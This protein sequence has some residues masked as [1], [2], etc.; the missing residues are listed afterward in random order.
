MYIYKNGFSKNVFLE[1]LKTNPL[2]KQIMDA[3]DTT[4]KELA[5]TPIPELEYSKFKLF[6]SIGDRI[7]YE[8]PYFD[9][10][11]RLVGFTVRTW[12]FG[13]KE[14]I[15]ELENILWA[16]CNEFSWALPAHVGG[17]TMGKDISRFSVDLFAS[18]TGQSICETLSLCGDLLDPFVTQRCVNEVFRRIIEPFEENDVEKYR[19][20]WQDALSNWATVCGGS[21]GMCGVYLIED[22]A[23]LK[24]LTNRAAYSCNKFIE[25]CMDD[26]CCLEGNAYWT[27]AM[28]YYV[29]FMELLKS[30]TGEDIVKDK[31]KFENIINFP[32][33]QCLG[34][35]KIPAFSDSHENGGLYFGIMCKL[36]DSYGAGMPDS[37]YYYNCA[38]RTST[39]GDTKIC[40]AVRNIAWFNPSLIKDTSEKKDV[41]FPD[42]QWAIKYGE[43]D[44]I[45]A[46]KGGHNGEPHNHNDIGSFMFIK[47]G[48]TLAADLGAPLYTREYFHGGRYSYLNAASWGHSV[49]IINGGY[50]L[51]GK[52]HRATA[53][54]VDEAKVALEIADAYNKEETGLEKL[55]RTAIF[56]KENA[57]LEIK[58]RF[59]FSKD[60][61]TVIQRVVTHLNTEKISDNEVLLKDG[62]TAVGKIVFA[63]D[64]ELSI[65]FDS[66]TV[67]NTID[68]KRSVSLIDF[69]IAADKNIE[70]KYTIMGM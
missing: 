34:K 60:K 46:I 13:K 63:G 24:K 33:R 31:K 19:L 53:F 20:W 56:D 48:V 25:S 57:S 14:D 52:E 61:N 18:E 26:G 29:S 35:G 68:V 66:Y 51:S 23:R 64:G 17:I 2:A 6:D 45:L 36:H 62:E 11:R 12:L 44:S 37:G 54:N 32:V 22:E 9:R 10:R 38:P 40:S 8:K 30:R 4:C 69:E 41:V 1:E 55:S 43:T 39:K 67:H 27:Y 47:N 42:G 49:P 3:A 65:S 7:I 28:L 15:T 59:V 21:V 70:T 5:G 50:Q 58:D 16:I